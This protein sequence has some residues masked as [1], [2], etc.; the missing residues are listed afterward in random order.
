MQAWLAKYRYVLMGAVLLLSAVGLIASGRTPESD[1]LQNYVSACGWW[2]GY[3]PNAPIQAMRDVCF[4]NTEIYFSFERSAHPPLAT[5][6]TVPFA[7]LSWDIARYLWLLVGWA[8]IVWGWYRSRATI[9]VCLATLGLWLYGLLLG[10]LEPLL[11]ALLAGAVA[12]KPR[13]LLLAG[14]LVGIA[15]ALKVY[16]AV[17]IIGLWLSGHRRMAIGALVGGALSAL[18]AELV[19]GHQVT[20]AWLAYAPVNA[21]IHVDAVRNLSLVRVVRTILP[22]AAPIGI[23]LVAGVALT[24]PLWKALRRGI[25]LPTMLPVMLLISPLCWSHYLGLLALIKINRPE[26]IVLLLCGMLQLLFWVRLM[27]FLPAEN[28]AIVAYGP[29]LL[30]LL[31]LWYRATAL[32]R[33]EQS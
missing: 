1:F 18:I 8:C 6:V 5:L 15:A 17:L 3:D 31:V 16:P 14:S 13:S 19:L 7:L 23:A 10:A 28:M 24:A 22:D 2:H 20:A 29:L 12:L 32:A 25:W 21:Q 11:F 33:A 4:P 30:V 9:W 26:Q 27:P